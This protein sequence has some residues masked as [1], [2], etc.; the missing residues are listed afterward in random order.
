MDSKEQQT[1]M[2]DQPD[3][4]RN[5]A[6]DDYLDETTPPIM[7]AGIKIVPSNALYE[8]D[9]E[10]YHKH[11]KHFERMKTIDRVEFLQYLQANKFYLSVDEREELERL[12]RIIQESQK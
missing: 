4:D 12:I 5:E 10:A 3:N 11:A 2:Y 9:K 8:A 7:I 1:S 6:F